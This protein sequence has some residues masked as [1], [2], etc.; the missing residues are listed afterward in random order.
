[1][2]LLFL[3]FFF[4][5]RGDGGLGVDVLAGHELFRAP[6]WHAI[7]PKGIYSWAALSKILEERGA[8]ASDPPPDVDVT[9]RLYFVPSHDDEGQP[10]EHQVH[11]MFYVAEVGEKLSVTAPEKNLC[12]VALL[13]DSLRP[14]NAL[15]E[16]R[17]F[18]HR[19]ITDLGVK[20][21]K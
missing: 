9:K 13:Q 1:E 16:S 2:E 11:G 3:N 14:Y 6:V 21:S 17:P 20:K 5:I 7:V 15:P 4:S 19:Y 10:L 8:D 12:I 18:L